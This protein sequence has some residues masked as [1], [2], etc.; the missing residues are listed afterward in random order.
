M[1]SPPSA[2][3]YRSKRHRPCDQCRS[4]KLGCQTGDGIPCQRCRTA[5]IDCTFDNPPPKRARLSEPLS[6]AVPSMD[7]MPATS[8]DGEGTFARDASHFKSPSGSVEPQFTSFELG[9]V[10]GPSPASGILL[11]TGSRPPTQFVQSIDRLEHGYA[12]LFGAS[13]ESD[14]WL[15]R[16]CRFDDSGMKY[17]YKVHF[18]NAGGVPTAQR[19]PVHFMISSGDLSAGAKEET[20][21]STGQATREHLDCLV[22]PEYG[23]RLVALFVKYVFPALPVISRS[24]L[25]LTTPSYQ[26]P[27]QS[28]LAKVPLHLLAAIYASAFPFVANDDYLCVLNTYH[29][30]PVQRLWRLVYELVCEEIHTPR[31]AV[32]QAALLYI[33][34]Q[35]TDEARYTTA[36]TP[37]IW[38]FVGQI[39]GL[40]CSLGVHIECRMWGIPAWEKRLRRRLWWAVYAE[41]KWRSLLMGRPP[42]IHPAEWDVSDLDE[43]DFLIGPR[44]GFSTSSC[45]TEIP[46]RYLVNLARIAEE[47][48][49]TFYTLRASQVL[50]ANFDS[51]AELG[52]GLLEKLNTW[53]STLPE[54]FRLP[55]WSKSVH[56]QAPYPTSIHFAYLLLVVFVYRAM[57]RPMAR[58]SSPPMIFDLEEMSANSPLPVDDPAMD[59]ADLSGIE[60]LPEMPMSDVSGTSELTLHAAEKCATIVVN[61]TRRLTPSDFTGFWYSWSRIG[62]ATA[63]NFLMLLLVQAPNSAHAT[64][65]KYLVESWLQVLRCQSQSFPLVKLGLARLDA[66]HW[67]GLE[68]TFV[69]PLHVREAATNFEEDRPI[70]G[71]A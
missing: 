34:Q 62:F 66:L 45:D 35:P 63:S 71:V 60:S 3:P 70:H 9:P 53:Y 40:A 57:L 46:F 69:L 44:Q 26:L 28:A 59:F 61:F 37:F 47:I 17:F 54:T 49:E 20:R 8:Q 29:A 38:S 13:A 33:H 56:G 39:V 21:V 11:P 30:S 5:R 12:Q 50:N 51:S 58:S 10:S 32:L 48:H 22:P 65:G 19:I 14:P 55:N 24:Q 4:R 36:D 16:H 42:F 1:S 67:A 31:L 23:R 25:G 52:R 68:D 41:D 15:L 27:E 6:F 7:D 18:R 64:R 43:G 2:R